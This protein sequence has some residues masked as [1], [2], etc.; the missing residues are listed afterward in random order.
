MELIDSLEGWSVVEIL[1]ETYF[2]T[3][4][5][6][7]AFGHAALDLL[8]KEE[9]EP[10]EILQSVHAAASLPSQDA[11]VFWLLSLGS[12]PWLLQPDFVG[13]V[14]LPEAYRESSVETQCF[15]RALLQGKTLFAFTLV[16]HAW[17][18]E[19]WEVLFTI[20]TQKRVRDEVHRLLERLRDLESFVWESRAAAILLVANA[21]RSRK[22]PPPLRLELA[23][24]VMEKVE[25]WKGLEGRRARRQYRIRTEALGSECGRTTLRN[26]EDNLQEIRT[27]MASLRGCAYW[28]TVAEDMGGWKAIRKSDD[29]KE[30]FY[31]LYF[32]DDI[33]DEWSAA[34]Q[35]KSH[36]RGVLIGTLTETTHHSKY[37]RSLYG[38]ATSNGLEA[39]TKKALAV[40]RGPRSWTDVYE[41]SR[42]KWKETAAVWRLTPVRKK[43]LVLS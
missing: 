42:A 38:G 3:A 13:H 27:P 12:E 4:P 11:S 26:T 32:P 18:S 39:F 35:E 9:L 33:P 16:R 28:E 8:E 41:E 22:S 7:W 30:A 1:L 15:A 5:S 14:A 10:E 24:E 36:G 23:P 43:I 29:H 19:T 34:D 40:E 17:T 20:A 31:D 37:L 25:E 6:A 21:N 2:T